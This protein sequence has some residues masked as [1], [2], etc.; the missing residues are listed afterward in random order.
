MYTVND[1]QIFITTHNRANYLKESIE[2]LLNQTAGIKELIVLDN[3]SND[4]TEEVV[5]K[6]SNKGVKYI[7]TYG[8]LGNYKKAK[9]TYIFTKIQKLGLTNGI[10]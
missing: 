2:S 6:Y 4:N 9:E 3:E 5:K 10:F 7:K 8:F 1:I